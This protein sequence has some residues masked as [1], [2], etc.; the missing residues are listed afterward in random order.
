MIRNNPFG[1]RATLNVDAMSVDFQV[2]D[3]KNSTKDKEVVIESE[4]FKVS[5]VVASN[6][7][8]NVALYGLSKLLQDRSSDIPTG[9]GKL[10]AMREVAALLQ[11]GEWERERKVGAPVVRPEVEALAQFKGVPVG[12]IQ[13]ALRKYDKAARDA[14]LANPKI[15]ELAAKIKAA[16]EN[17]AVD[18]SDLA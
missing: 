18:L 14:I 2:I 9:P 8:K 4:S 15:V 6:L 7:H 5:E 17:A 11:S 1:L 12:D 16:R 3:K 10:V 13:N